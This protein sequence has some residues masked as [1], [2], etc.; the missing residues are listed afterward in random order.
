M[1]TLP[2]AIV[3]RRGAP[4]TAAAFEG[5]NQQAPLYPSTSSFRRRTSLHPS[6]LLASTWTPWFLVPVVFELFAVGLPASA[7]SQRQSPDRRAL[8]S[9]RYCLSPNS[10][11]TRQRRYANS[12]DGKPSSHRRD[13]ASHGR[14]RFVSQTTL[15]GS[16]YRT[17]IKNISESPW[18]RREAVGPDG[19]R[20]RKRSI[21]H[22]DAAVVNDRVP[23]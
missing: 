13:L 11:S 19:R 1:C 18:F 14:T 5:Q 8:S 4:C 7:Y 17:P 2:H 12:P 10:S 15:A 23:V 3:T 21:V 6:S 20:K 22:G 16:S 9:A